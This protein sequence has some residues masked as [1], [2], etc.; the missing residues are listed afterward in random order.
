MKLISFRMLC[1]KCVFNNSIDICDH[2]NNKT[3][4]RSSKHC[5]IWKKLKEPKP[6]IVYRPVDLYPERRRIM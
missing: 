6:V 5:P 2:Y 3:W 1:K 4:K